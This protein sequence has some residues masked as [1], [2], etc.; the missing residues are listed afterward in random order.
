MSID[1]ADFKLLLFF[2]VYRYLYE[3]FLGKGRSS[4]W[5]NME[6]WETFFGDIVAQERQAMGLNDNP[7]QLIE[8]Y[9][10]LLVLLDSVG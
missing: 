9:N 3:E 1:N 7:V 5:D 10:Y 2:C 6:F 4:L 8:R